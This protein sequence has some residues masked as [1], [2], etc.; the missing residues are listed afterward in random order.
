MHTLPN[1]NVRKFE[2]FPRAEDMTPRRDPRRAP[3]G[4]IEDVPEDLRS[5]P[6]VV[7]DRAQETFFGRHYPEPNFKIGKLNQTYHKVIEATPG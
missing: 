6:G 4:T 3:A 2:T 1:T 7:R 5:V